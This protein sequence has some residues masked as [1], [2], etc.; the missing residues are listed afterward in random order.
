MGSTAMIDI[1]ALGAVVFDSSAD[2]CAKDDLLSD[3]FD[4]VTSL[5]TLSFPPSDVCA[6]AHWDYSVESVRRAV[7]DYIS[8]YIT[9][10]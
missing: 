10:L 7:C 4:S 3:V 5:T 6:H 1:D 8:R 9:S 2:S